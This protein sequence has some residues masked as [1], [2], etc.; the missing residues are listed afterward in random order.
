MDMAAKLT[1]KGQI[2]VPKPIRDALA[3]NPGDQV[4][5]RL[6]SDRA[7]LAR[8]PDF[9]E[10]GGTVAAPPSRRGATWDDIRRQTRRARAKA[11]S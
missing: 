8:T 2:T 3:L 9:L 10:L 5:F 1:S 7:I 11:R 4:L 6:E